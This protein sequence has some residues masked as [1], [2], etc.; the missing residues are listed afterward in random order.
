MTDP[1]MIIVSNFFVFRHQDVL[2]VFSVFSFLNVNALAFIC[3]PKSNRI[4]Y[5]KVKVQ[6]FS[7]S[8]GYACVYLKPFSVTQIALQ[9]GSANIVI[10]L[11]T[12]ILK[13]NVSCVLNC[14]P[15][16]RSRLCVR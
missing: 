3:Q 5:A 2:P 15:S 11:L 4:K 13:N 9:L 14:L 7:A 16:R 10:V 8:F 6:S 12:Y 1:L